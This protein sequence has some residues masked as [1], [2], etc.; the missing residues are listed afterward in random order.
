[1]Y[2]TWQY[3]VDMYHLSRG[4]KGALVFSL[5]LVISIKNKL[6]SARTIIASTRTLVHVYYKAKNSYYIHEKKLLLYYTRV[7]MDV[8]PF[9]SN[10]NSTEYTVAL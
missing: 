4:E 3:I 1:M 10:A 2:N 7:Y 9:N 8:L 5:S 6:N